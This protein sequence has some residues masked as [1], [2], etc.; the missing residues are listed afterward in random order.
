[1]RNFIIPFAFLAALPVAAQAEG[2]YQVE[3]DGMLFKYSVTT[4]PSG[5]REITG[6]NLKT[7]EEF[8]FRAK[9]R[10]VRGT[11]GGTQVSFRLAQ[12]VK[13]TPAPV[14]ASN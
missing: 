7:G 10:L 11:V 13:S 1:M 6:T 8:A 4:K 9:G 14:L 12:P 5:V 2:P 3:R